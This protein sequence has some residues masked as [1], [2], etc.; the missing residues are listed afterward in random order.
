MTQQWVV[1]GRGWIWWTEGVMDA[2]DQVMRRAAPSRPVWG[3]PVTPIGQV[4][5]RGQLSWAYKILNGGRGTPDR[6]FWSTN[7]FMYWLGFLPSRKLRRGDEHLQEIGGSLGTMLWVSIPGAPWWE[8]GKRVR[9][10][11]WV[12]AEV[13]GPSRRV[14]GKPMSMTEMWWESETEA[15]TITSKKKDGSPRR[16]DVHGQDLNLVGG[17]WFLTLTSEKTRF[18]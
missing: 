9:L 15:R 17:S 14:E 5:G 7:V 10:W 2:E 8:R 12:S 11:N 6:S 16:R 18:H 13:P 1:A 3:P 4:A